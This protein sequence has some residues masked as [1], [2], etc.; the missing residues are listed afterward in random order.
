MRRR[1]CAVGC[2]GWIGL[3]SDSITL[4]FCRIIFAST[5]ALFHRMNEERARLTCDS[6]GLKCC[7]RHRHPTRELK[8]CMHRS[9]APD[10]NSWTMNSLCTHL[11]ARWPAGRWLTFGSSSTSMCAQPCHTL[12]SH[13]LTNQENGFPSCSLMLASHC[14]LNSDSCIRVTGGQIPA[15]IDRTHAS[16]FSK[17]VVAGWAQW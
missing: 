11:R 17:M 15:P 7:I 12:L 1:L 9:P 6:R 13:V 2:G 3:V 10:I 4:D 5:A 16:V 8:C 14:P